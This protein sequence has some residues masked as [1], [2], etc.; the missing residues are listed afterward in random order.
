MKQTAM[1]TSE[2]KRPFYLTLLFFISIFMF[3]F[4]PTIMKAENNDSVLHLDFEEGTESFNLNESVEIVDGIAQATIPN[5]TEYQFAR[6]MV[7]PVNSND[8][9]FSV[10]STQNKVSYR[11]KVTGHEAAEVDYIAFR[12]KGTNNTQTFITLHRDIEL[13]QWYEGE[14]TLN[15]MTASDGK[16][17][18][19]IGDEITEVRADAKNHIEEENPIT[20]HVDYMHIDPPNPEDEKDPDVIELEQTLQNQVANAQ[21]G[22]EIIVPNG[23]Y[24]DFE[25]TL[26]GNGVENNPI[27][28]KAETP[29]EVIFTGNVHI[30]LMGDYL[31]FRDFH[32]DQANPSGHNYVLGLSG[33]SH[34][35]ITGN[36]FHNS[37]PTD[38][39]AGVIRVR[40]NSQY[41][42]IDHNT[43]K[44][45]VSMG[46]AIRVN[47]NNN[48]EN[49]YNK[50]DHNYFKDIPEVNEIYPEEGNNGLESIQIGQG[51]GYEQVDVYT[52]VESNLF[53]NIIG[54]GSEI[55]SN[56]TA[57]NVYRDNTFKNSDSGFTLRFGA[58][59]TVEENV[60][61]RT[62]FGIRVTDENQTI[63]N[64]YMYQV[65]QGF[66]VLAGRHD[67][68]AEQERQ[69]NYIPVQ[70]ATISNNVIMYPTSQAIV[71]GDGFS[72]NPS[73][74]YTY[75]EPKDSMITNNRIVLNEGEAIHQVIGENIH[76]ENNRV[77]LIGN[78]AAIGNIETGLQK[79][80]LKMNYDSNSQ[81]YHTKKGKDHPIPLTISDVGPTNKWWLKGLKETS[82][83]LETIDQSSINENTVTNLIKKNSEIQVN[84][85]P[86]KLIP[87]VLEGKDYVAFDIKASNDDFPVWDT[88]KMTLFEEHGVE[89]WSAE[90][91]SISEQWHHV[92]IPLEEFYLSSFV[93]GNTFKDKRELHSMKLQTL[94]GIDVEVKNFSTG[95]FHTED[96]TI[97]E[98]NIQL[99]IGVDKNL[100]D[101]VTHATYKG[102]YQATISAEEIIWEAM[103]EDLLTINKR[104]LSAVGET[105]ESAITATYRNRTIEIPVE[106]II[107][108][109]INVEASDE[110]QPENSKENTID[111]DLS[112]RWSAEGEQWIMYELREELLINQVQLAWMSGDERKS[113]FDIEV[114]TDGSSWT[115]VF[116]GENSG[117]TIELET[118]SFEEIPAKYVRIIGH[119]NSEN[120]W[121]SLTEVLIPEIE[122]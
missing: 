44:G 101:L 41:N 87:H 61:L 46:I 106:I 84:G 5:P 1:Y 29:G 10:E 73:S 81:I 57:N 113:Y 116:S 13:D 34:S 33:L 30:T 89:E 48:L 28:I 6:V 94:S 117:E 72:V 50:I 121:N 80:K 53:E 17:K 112:T 22:D 83:Q 105:G 4:L 122:D 68:E 39:Y 32:F 78:D 59:N 97:N 7:T 99:G 26:T 62:K 93:N 27:T 12:L 54:D 82:D 31:T 16:N 79:Q 119:G 90:I 114:S 109:I 47:D 91:G 107:Q 25:A 85:H 70:H 2:I 102:G 51:Y 14:F 52:T 45:N 111:G 118:Y 98:D 103:D 86:S 35:R 19:S 43:L 11:I 38:P 110:P 115:E 8:S 55:I 76:Y 75:Y 66:R 23:T 9:L 100:S 74:Q 104:T 64:N 67:A 56:K 60:F 71:V 37:G 40:N 63:N 36:F 69:M 120:N 65:G 108:T 96:F 88:L 21:P 95:Q 92:I 3:L 24:Q 49:Q 15:E 77:E 18:F 42:R 20:I 58:N